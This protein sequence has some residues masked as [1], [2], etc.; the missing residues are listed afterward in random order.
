LRFDFFDES[1]GNDAVGCADNGQAIITGPDYEARRFF[2]F[3]YD[4]EHFC[5]FWKMN[6]LG[7][8]DLTVLDRRLVRRAFHSRL[9]FTLGR[10]RR[11]TSLLNNE[12][13]DL[14]IVEKLRR[15]DYSTADLFPI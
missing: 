14:Q 7:K 9:Y 3:R 12:R 15:N 4:D 11:R 5:V 1:R 6:R 8:L 2:S 10:S 13:S